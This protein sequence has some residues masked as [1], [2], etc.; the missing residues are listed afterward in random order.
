MGPALTE[1]GS[2]A[3]EHLNLLHLTAALARCL[4]SPNDGSELL[5]AAAAGQRLSGVAAAQGDC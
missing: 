1:A 2:K 4:M 3:A 5:A